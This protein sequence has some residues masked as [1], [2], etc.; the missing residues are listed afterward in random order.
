MPQLCH[1][2]N[3]SGPILAMVS[4]KH[5]GMR[6]RVHSFVL[7]AVT[8]LLQS[9]DSAHAKKD[10]WL[11]KKPAASQ[12]PLLRPIITD[13]DVFVGGIH[14]LE[15]QFLFHE[16]IPKYRV[17]AQIKTRGFWN[18]V[19]PWHAELSSHGRIN[20]N[21]FEPEFHNNTSQWS[22]DK[23]KTITMRF[24]DK[25][26]VTTEFEPHEEPKAN[27]ESVTPEQSRGSLDPLSVILQ[28]LGDLAVNQSCVANEPAFDGKRRFDLISED[29]G[30]ANTDPDKYGIYKGNARRCDIYFKMVSGKWL[31]REHSLF[32]QHMDGEK[33]NEAFRIW[34]A[35]LSPELPELAVRAENSSAW[36]RIVVHLK[37]WRYAG[38]D[39][40]P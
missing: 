34:L 7:I 20:G 32:W 21:R 23:A 33:G 12:L 9:A 36:G 5:V 3:N 15:A 17:T 30:W 24:D 40:S 29:R 8:L 39:K 37:G 22:D 14:L 35:K 25:N 10:P 2:T 26:Y 38:G 31:D 27:R 28:L 1:F 13:Y 6:F 11:S 16:E 18:Y 4:L 19:M